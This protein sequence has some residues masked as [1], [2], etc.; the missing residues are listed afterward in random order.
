MQIFK[1]SRVHDI[2]HM[3]QINKCL[4]AHVD[5]VLPEVAP[6]YPLIVGLEEKPFTPLPTVTVELLPLHSSC[7]RRRASATID[8]RLWSSSGHT[9]S[10]P[11]TAR[12]PGT[13]TSTSTPASTSSPVCR[14]RLFP[15]RA[16]RRGEL[17][18]VSLLLPFSS[19]RSHHRPGPLLGHFP[20]DQ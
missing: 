17:P 18:T 4:K 15:A 19:N 14:R 3:S 9:C 13:S 10:T 11:S 8:R 2:F 5:A 6:L 16:R 1:N 7:H 20:A 12:V